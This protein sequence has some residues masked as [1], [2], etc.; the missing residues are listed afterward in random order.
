MGLTGLRVL[1]SY[2]HEGLGINAFLG[3][4]HFSTKV[5]FLL[6][7]PLML[8]TVPSFLQ[9]LFVEICALMLLSLYVIIEIS[10]ANMSISIIWA[11]LGSSTA[12]HV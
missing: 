12:I 8:L 3:L 10:A 4:L 11:I 9:S 6:F 1:Q 2:S 7:L 5:S